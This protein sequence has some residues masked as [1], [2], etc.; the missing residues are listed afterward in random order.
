[1]FLTKQRILLAKE[2]S[3]YGVDPTP[4]VASNAVEAKNI[5]VNVV[6]DPLDRDLQNNSLSPNSPVMGKRYIEVSFDVE[7][8]G[9]GTKGTA[10]RIG[11][12][13]EACGMSETASVGSSVV[14]K[15]SST[16]H[17]SVTF[18]IYDYQGDGSSNSR[19]HKV[20]GAR[21]TWDI[22]LA[23]GNVAI[24]SFQFQGIYNAPTDVSTPSAPTYETT[25]PPVVNSAGLSLNSVTTLVAQEMAL[26]LANA[27]SQREDLS[28]T[29]GLAGFVITGRKPTGSLN[30]EAVLA[31]VYDYAT[32][33]VAGTQRALSIVVGSA[34]G[35]KLTITA[36]KLTIDAINDEERNGV[37]VD[38]I[39]FHLGKD[40]GDDEIQFKYE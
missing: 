32:D 19:L 36:P 14:Y 38:G 29:T 30:P 1:M 31:S 13:L 27:I 21:G 6:G 10:P 18:Y 37:L 16:A 3:S 22:R 24:I 34:T 7:I 2:E 15:P 8:K 4:V 33:L 12:L 25:T 39:P 35:N 11:D 28:A 20:T 26:S 5:K 9:S 40:S 23:S 17:K